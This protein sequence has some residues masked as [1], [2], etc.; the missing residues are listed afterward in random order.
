MNASMALWLHWHKK[1]G[2]ENRAV[3]IL[4]SLKC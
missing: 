1:N 2:A 4:F 3:V